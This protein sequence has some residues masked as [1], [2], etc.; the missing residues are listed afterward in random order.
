MKTPN[1]PIMVIAIMLLLSITTSAQEIWDHLTQADSTYFLITKRLDSIMVTDTSI[2]ARLAAGGEDDDLMEYMRWKQFWETRVDKDGKFAQYFDKI[3]DARL[4]SSCSSDAKEK[5]VKLGPD[6]DDI[7]IQNIGQV[8]AI[9]VNPDNFNDI[10]LAGGN[11]CF[12]RSQDAGATWVNTADDE[13][14]SYLGVND[15]QL[16]R[17]KSNSSRLYAGT[18]LLHP[19]VHVVGN[20]DYINGREPLGSGIVGSLDGGDTW[21]ILPGFDELNTPTIKC[22]KEI[23][24]ISSAD[25][26]YVSLS[27]ADQAVKFLYSG[28]FEVCSYVYDPN[29]ATGTAYRKVTLFHNWDVSYNAISTGITSS[30]QF[31]TS[32]TGFYNLYISPIADQQTEVYV[33]VGLICANHVS[34]VFSGWRDATKLIKFSYNGKRRVYF[35]KR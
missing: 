30:D 25:L 28:P 16:I 34:G 32:K 3:K 14:L 6:H 29:D 7:P 5:W 26:A 18:Q 20:E 21:K 13:G 10:V 11:S 35:W 12:W 24:N 31:C 22:L 2:A 15:N 19:G 1:T 17:Q 23:Q 33:A 27:K 8:T 9:S 4:S